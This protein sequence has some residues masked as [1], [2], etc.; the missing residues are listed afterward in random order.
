MKQININAVRL[1]VLGGIMMA[2]AIVYPF[3]A[4]VLPPVSPPLPIQY[5]APKGSYWQNILGA[6][7]YFRDVGGNGWIRVVYLSQDPLRV[8]FLY[9]NQLIFQYEGTDLFMMGSSLSLYTS[10]PQSAGFTLWIY[11]MIIAYDNEIKDIFRMKNTFYWIVVGTDAQTGGLILSNPINLFYEL[12]KAFNIGYMDSANVE[13]HIEENITVKEFLTYFRNFI[14]YWFVD[15]CNRIEHITDN[16]VVCYVNVPIFAYE[17]WSGAT[18]WKTENVKGWLY[19]PDNYGRYIVP[20][21]GS[22]YP[23]TILYYKHNENRTAPPI[24]QVKLNM[25]GSNLF[26]ENIFFTYTSFG[27]EIYPYE[28][29]RR[30]GIQLILLSTG[31]I[32]LIG[33][34]VGALKSGGVIIGSRW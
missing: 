25:E 22:S 17:E 7:E 13:A 12:S 9:N 10:A 29:A 21:E 28:E 30:S 5:V 19:C 32:L 3:P 6:D 15:M 11:P 14:H 26:L 23:L 20:I 31:F 2:I 33:G 4:K 16:D 18:Y 34:F 1:M 24:V 8:G 27:A